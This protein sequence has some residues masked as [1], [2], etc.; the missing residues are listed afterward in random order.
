MTKKQ[1]DAAAAY[2]ARASAIR[3]VEG[4]IPCPDAEADAAHWNN[5]ALRIRGDMRLMVL[6]ILK[7]AAMSP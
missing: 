6:N 1:I 7:A 4:V 2:Y 5:T 3:A